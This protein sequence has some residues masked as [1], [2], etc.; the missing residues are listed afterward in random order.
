MSD[1]FL[2][3]T[4]IPKVG[5]VDESAPY[6]CRRVD[7]AVDRERL[8]LRGSDVPERLARGEVDCF[9]AV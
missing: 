6:Q 1:N 2:T 3:E 5:I 7:A 8:T 9:F 4:L